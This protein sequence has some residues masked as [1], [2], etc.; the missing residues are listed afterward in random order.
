MGTRTA[1]CSART[2]AE[3][4][5]RIRQRKRRRC[6]FHDAAAFSILCRNASEFITVQSVYVY[7]GCTMFPLE[8]QA[9]EP[10]LKGMRQRLEQNLSQILGKRS[11][12]LCVR[13]LI[14][15][16]AEGGKGRKRGNDG[17]SIRRKKQMEGRVRREEESPNSG[18]QDDR[19][20]RMSRWIEELLPVSDPRLGD[21][22]S[23]SQRRRGRERGKESGESPDKTIKLQVVYRIEDCIQVASMR[24][25]VS[26]PHV[27]SHLIVSQPLP[28]HLLVSHPPFLGS[29]I[30]PACPLMHPQLS[31]RL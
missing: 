31:S 1:C 25:Y 8:S 27:F 30:W 3:V 28:L 14:L 7:T 10:Q 16:P 19:E 5:R 13:D 9:K 4:S 2:A 11:S 18:P 29:D 23:G 21:T 17:C 6:S 26:S 24:L 12:P 15:I 22:D 20:M